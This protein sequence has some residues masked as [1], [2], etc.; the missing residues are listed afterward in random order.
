MRNEYNDSSRDRDYAVLFACK[1]IQVG[2]PIVLQVTVKK[3]QQMTF[4][5][6]IIAGEFVHKSTNNII[7]IVSNSFPGRVLITYAD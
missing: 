4:T 2:H 3:E 1:N 7:K 5:E 6:R